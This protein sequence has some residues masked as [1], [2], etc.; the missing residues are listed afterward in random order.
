MESPDNWSDLPRHPSVGA[1]TIATEYESSLSSTFS[2]LDLAEDLQAKAFRALERY[3]PLRPS[4][5]TREL[6]MAFLKHLP[7]KGRL[8]LMAEIDEH[9]DDAGKLRMLRDFLVNAILKPSMFF[10]R[11]LDEMCI[12]ISCIVKLAGGQ[13]PATSLLSALEFEDETEASIA[14]TET[15]SRSEHC[16]LRK[17]C[18]KR[19]DHQCVVT[20]IVDREHSFQLTSGRTSWPQTWSLV[21]RAHYPFCAW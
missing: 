20:G 19:D 14:N 6:L 16:K 18:M 15:S 17:D 12:L 7:T 2:S 21:L 5:D 11:R 4:D 8:V 3:T 9:A 10:P 1:E 13:S